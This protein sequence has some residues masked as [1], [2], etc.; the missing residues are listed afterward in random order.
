MTDSGDVLR[1]EAVSVSYPGRGLFRRRSSG[2]VVRSI[3]LQVGAG[4]V[5]ALVGESGS[6]KST[7][8]RAICGLVP[9]E[10]SI[11]VAGRE[12]R[13]SDGLAAHRQI[14]FQDPYSSL[15]PLMTVGDSIAEPLVLLHGGRLNSYRGDV[16]QLL[17]SVNLPVHFATRLPSALSGGQRQRVAI[18]RALAT[19]PS[20]I[21]CDEAVSALDATTQGEVVA[22]LES[23]RRERG[24]SLLFIAHDLALVK[25]FA[26]RTAVMYL[27]RIVEE[28]PTVDI[29]RHPRHPYTQALLAAVPVPNPRVQRQRNVLLPLGDPPDPSDLPSGCPFHP[30]CPDVMDACLHD[31]PLERRVDTRRVECHLYLPA[32]ET[33]MPIATSARTDR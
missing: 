22:L 5:V 1:L 2:T 27:G 26:D 15:D 10:G 32:Q 33:D 8:A 9:Y 12:V 30:R 3:D 17:E 31:R 24:L 11:A 4:E 23:L 20:L 19:E 14:I 28:G 13:N 7:T 25:H 21:I 6:G 18:A 29:F 16:E